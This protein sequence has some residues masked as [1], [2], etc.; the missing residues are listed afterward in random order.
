MPAVKRVK[1]TEE[2]VSGA[3]RLL[4]GLES[5]AN[6]EDP[7]VLAEMIAIRNELDAATV[8]VVKRL[9]EV[10]Y[11]WPAIAF[12]LNVTPETAIKRYAKRIA[13]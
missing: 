1:D 10:G 3:R 5:R 4:R 8:R 9:R 12:S 11:T 6:D 13:S 2:V 7:W